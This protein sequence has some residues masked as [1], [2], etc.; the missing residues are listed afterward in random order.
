[1]RRSV[2]VLAVLSVLTIAGSALGQPITAASQPA[3]LDVRVAGDHSL[4]VTLKPLTFRDDFPATPAVVDRRYAASALT[5]QNIA[6]AIRKSVGGMDVEVKP[7]PLT[8][9]VRR[10]GRLIQELVFEADGSVSF[11]LDDQPVL[12]M[13]EGG[14]RPAAGRPWREQPV[15]FDRRGQLDT[16]EP[17]WQSDMYGSR[18]PVAMLLGT[19]GWGLFVGTP[20]MQVDLR[21]IARPLHPGETPAEADR[22]RPSG[23]SS[24]TSARDCRPRIR[25]SPDSSICS[26]FDAAD[27]PAALRD[28][29]PSPVRRRC[30]RS[31]RSATCSRTARSRTTRSSSAS[32]IAS[33]PAGAARRSDLSRH[34]LRAA[35]LE[36]QAAL[37]RLQP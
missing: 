14:P 9:S 29:P 37:V 23:T 33:A 16:M 17:R 15:Q 25:S 20:W 24:R 1:M 32:S 2:T 26:V 12:G 22:P 36:H 34:R 35:R 7:A 10:A 30:R 8:L 27:P 31:G 6:T 18:N 21:E 13:G 11:R 19:A 3:R 4:R 5:V 28:S